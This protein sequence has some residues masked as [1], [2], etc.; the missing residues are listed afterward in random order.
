M[1]LKVTVRVVAI[2]TGAVSVTVRHD[3]ESYIR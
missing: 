3:F 2:E 1:T